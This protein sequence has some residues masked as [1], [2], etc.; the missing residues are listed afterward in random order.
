MSIIS[1]SPYN[2]LKQL[3]RGRTCEM[4]LVENKAGQK[5]ALKQYNQDLW[6][7]DEQI[8]EVSILRQLD[9]K[10]IMKMHAETENGIVLELLEGGELFDLIDIPKKP[11]PVKIARFYFRQLLEGLLYMHK[12][13]IAHRDIK[14]ENILLDKECN[15]K[16][17]D[18]GFASKY[19]PE[20]RLLR[21]SLGTEGYISPEKLKYQPYDPE[22]AD[23]FAA[24]ITLF[25]M[26]YGFP[27]VYKRASRE[28]PLYKLHFTGQQN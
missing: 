18:L 21:D 16:I 4:H 23:V 17:A 2:K 8:N 19:N 27:P 9:H 15:L 7:K 10:N 11:F 3:G 5:F 12:K 20:E 22:K 1:Q 13:S 28:D 6:K 24:A 26:L 14:L 25:C